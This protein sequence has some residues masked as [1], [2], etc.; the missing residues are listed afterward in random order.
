M[1]QSQRRE[2][3]EE[4]MHSYRHIS[5]ILLKGVREAIVDATDEHPGLLII[6]KVIAEKGALSQGEIAKELSHSNAAVSR[7]VAILQKKG[8]VT[9]E[10]DPDN[11][12]V[13]IVSMTQEGTVVYQRVRAVAEERCAEILAD[14][15]D[16]L[17]QDIIEINT[18]LYEKISTKQKR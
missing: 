5:Q 9:A 6:L 17:L 2:T 1:K 4:L 18:R 11:R 14:V 10:P 3:I 7:Q 16:D 8:F 13:I 15:S 12:R